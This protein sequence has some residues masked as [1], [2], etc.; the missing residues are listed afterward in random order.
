[1][2]LEEPQI[3]EFEK[4]YVYLNM[5]KTL[6]T[7]CLRLFKYEYKN[8]TASI[9]KPSAYILT[10]KRSWGM[11]SKALNFFWSKGFFQF[12]IKRIN[13]WHADFYAEIVHI[14]SKK[15]LKYRTI[16]FI[17]VLSSFLKIGLT[18]AVLTCFEYLFK[19]KS[20]LI[21]LN[22]WRSITLASILA[23]FAEL[24]SGPLTL[25]TLSKT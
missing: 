21:I 22:K 2:N 3:I 8:V 12:S 24:P 11:G 7:F 9:V 6:Y 25:F 17:F 23:N 1:M 10:I 18:F 5:R 16:F 4:Y 15:K 20:L 19:D 14:F 13:T